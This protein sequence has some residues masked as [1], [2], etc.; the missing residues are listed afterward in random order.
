MVDNEKIRAEAEKVWE[1]ALAEFEN[2][3]KAGVKI[4]EDCARYFKEAVA[5]YGSTHEWTGKMEAAVNESIAA[6]NKRMDE[7][8]AVMRKNADASVEMLKKAWSVGQGKSVEEMQARTHDL[9]KG[10]LKAMEHNARSMVKAHVSA[11]ENWVALVK[12]G[13]RG[14]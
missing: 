1:Q 8:L 7:A 2:A 14:K 12:R 3:L 4:Q 13:T 5:N 11:L 6:A 10:A 9:W